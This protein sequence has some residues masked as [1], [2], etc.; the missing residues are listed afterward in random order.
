M[1]SLY[2]NIQILIFSLK[3]KYTEL[4]YFK[5]ELYL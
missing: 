5:D 3:F 2:A 1:F 4:L